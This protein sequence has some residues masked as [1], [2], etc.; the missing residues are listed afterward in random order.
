MSEAK[1]PKQ[2]KDGKRRR[3]K[4]KALGELRQAVKRAEKCQRALL[5]KREEILDDQ[6]VAMDQVPNWNTRT[7]F[8]VIPK[9]HNGDV[10][11]DWKPVPIGHIPVSCTQ[12]QRTEEREL[13]QANEELDDKVHEIAERIGCMPLDINIHSGQITGGAV[14]GV[15]TEAPEDEIASL[16]DFEVPTDDDAE[17]SKADPDDPFQG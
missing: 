17:T 8:D 4:G 10:P 7:I 9:E 2:A 5:R 16:M 3:L 12:Q 11:E 14:V 13:E 1:K 6:D 15:D